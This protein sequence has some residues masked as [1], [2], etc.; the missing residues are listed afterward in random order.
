MGNILDENFQELFEK[1]NVRENF[2]QLNISCIN[3]QCKKCVMKYFCGGRCRGE[4]FQ[5][6][7]DVMAPY[8]YCEEWKKAMEKIFWIL[9]EYPQW[10]NEKYLEISSKVGRYLNLWH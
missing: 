9:T 8:P 6:V 1:S 5:E 7:G 3:E 10:G 2:H 4:T